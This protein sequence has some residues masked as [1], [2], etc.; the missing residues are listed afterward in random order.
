M[1]D[2]KMEM[3]EKDHRVHIKVHEQKVQNL[4]YEHKNSAKEVI[5]ICE[6][7]ESLVSNCWFLPAPGKEG[8]FAVR[9]C[10]L[11]LVTV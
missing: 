8:G 4:E 10:E 3:M 9:A 11:Q 2:R 6:R 7:S 5:Y 1:K